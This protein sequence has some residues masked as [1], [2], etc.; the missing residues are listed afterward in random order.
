MRAL[1]SSKLN[2]GRRA[3]QEHQEGQAHDRFSGAYNAPPRDTQFAVDVPSYSAGNAQWSSAPYYPQGGLLA[4]VVGWLVQGCGGYLS[5]AT[6]GSL[7]FVPPGLNV[8]IY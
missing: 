6:S 4:G 1:M 8:D 7:A 2:A 3:D 5:L